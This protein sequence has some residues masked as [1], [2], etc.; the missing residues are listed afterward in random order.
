MRAGAGYLDLLSGGDEPASTGPNQDL[1]L[2]GVVPA[3][4]ERWWRPA[5]GRVFKGAFGPGMADEHRIA[6]LLLSLCPGDGVLDVACGIGNF[7][8]DFGRSVGSEG[9]VVGI[10][11]SPTMLERAVRDTSQAGLDQVAFIRGDAQNLP[12]RDHAFDAV[13]CFAALHLF[14]DP[15]SALDRMTAVLTPGGR[16]ALFTTAGY[17]SAAARLAEPAF[18]RRSGARVF[19]REE[20]ADALRQRGFVEIRQRVGGITQ[21]IGGRLE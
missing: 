12:F 16:I 7:S 21:F 9:L 19:E 3:V 20:L 2:S 15:E 18:A 6:R 17:R 1:I 10:D 13:C 8:R 11:V 14:A 5:L 4:Y